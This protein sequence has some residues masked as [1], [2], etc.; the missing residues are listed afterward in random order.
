MM[1]ALVEEDSTS[2]GEEDQ[3]DEVAVAV[4]VAGAVDTAAV[5]L[6]P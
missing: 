4:E 1:A 3:L 6:D 5:A 2:S